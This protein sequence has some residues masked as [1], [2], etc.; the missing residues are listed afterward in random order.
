LIRLL[1]ILLGW[2]QPYPPLLYG[3]GY[4]GAIDFKVRGHNAEGEAGDSNVVRFCACDVRPGPV[5][6]DAGSDGVCVI[7][8][9]PGSNRSELIACVMGAP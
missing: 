8:T 4:P 1:A 7:Y 3:V 2:D 9:P 5:P 6:V